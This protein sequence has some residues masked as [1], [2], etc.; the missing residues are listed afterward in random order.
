MN[1][2]GVEWTEKLMPRGERAFR[3]TDFG[4]NI[5]DLADRAMRSPTHGTARTAFTRH[6]EIIGRVQTIIEDRTLAA[7]FAIY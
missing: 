3:A 7:S 5:A 6:S 1:L 2:V 4:G